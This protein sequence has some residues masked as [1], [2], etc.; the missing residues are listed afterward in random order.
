LLSKTP[1]AETYKPPP[2]AR[3]FLE[4]LVLSF[5]AVLLLRWMHGYHI[6]HSFEGDYLAGF[7]LI[8]GLALLLVHHHAVLGSSSALAGPAQLHALLMAG[9]GAVIF[10]FLYSGWFDLTFSAAWLTPARWLRF[11]F[12]LLVL[13]PYHFAEEIVVGSP[14]ARGA[15][16]RLALAVSL[17]LVFWSALATGVF[18]LHSGE[19]L[20]VL[21]VP[22][23]AVFCV[24]QR[25]GMDIVRAQ[26]G[27]AS[28]AAIFGA[29]LMAGFCLAIFPVA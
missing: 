14:F 21:L 27:S 11:P 22:Y 12:F 17:R 16:P 2:A 4:F 6:L 10:L 23:L 24:L 26:T 5:S 28:S 29:I 25:L 18:L 20:L 1:A 7:L 15:L 19:I 8:T 13:F 3:L 9:L